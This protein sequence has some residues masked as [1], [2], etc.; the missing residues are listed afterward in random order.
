MY[1]TQDASRTFQ[2]GWNH[3]IFE[4]AHFVPQR[5]NT[6]AETCGAWP[7]VMVYLVLASDKVRWRATLGQ[8]AKV[9]KDDKL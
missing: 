4:S 8:E 9:L 6:R 2:K 1:G 5:A 7:M 3:M